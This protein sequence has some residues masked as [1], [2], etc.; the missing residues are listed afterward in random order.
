MNSFSDAYRKKNMKILFIIGDTYGEIKRNKDKDGA[1]YFTG[2][3]WD[4][5][6]LL[7][8]KLSD[9]YTFEHYYTD[10]QGLTNTNYDELVKYVAD[11]KYSIVIGNFYQ[12]RQ[13][14]TK[15]NFSIPTII[16]APAILHYPNN[17]MIGQL[18]TVAGTFIRL[19]LILLSVG[20]VMGVLL[21]YL[22]RKR[23][24]RPQSKGIV[25]YFKR[26]IF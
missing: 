19:I 25:K 11:N 5:W 16:D 8:E 20:L 13:R 1:W 18:K 15:V 23:F 17:T 22:D 6:K 4:L 3:G 21:A 26:V 7:E 12:T 14:E 9:R 24:I 2:F 10:E